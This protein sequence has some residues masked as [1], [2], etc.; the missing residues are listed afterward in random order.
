MLRH[1]VSPCSLSPTG[2]MVFN[3]TEPEMAASLPA[4]QPTVP[5]PLSPLPE[6]DLL[7]E[8]SPPT[9]HY[10]APPSWPVSFRSPIGSQRSST[11]WLERLALAQP[12]LEPQG[13]A[14]LAHTDLYPANVAID[15]S[16]SSELD[17]EEQGSHSPGAEAT[18]FAIR[19]P[20]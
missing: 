15:N 18:N 4:P 14:G 10:N 19:S 12:W 7:S 6:E 3:P 13:S 20:L 8:S 5:P 16:V 17:P 1:S 11:N 9:F 2:D